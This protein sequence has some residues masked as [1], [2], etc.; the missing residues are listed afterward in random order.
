MRRKKKID[1][2][3]AYSLRMTVTCMAPTRMQEL[4]DM[5][6]RWSQNHGISFA[7]EKCLVVAKEKI[8]LKIGQSILPQVESAKYLGIP[9]CAKGP[10]WN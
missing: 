7:P 10:M 9:F 4:L 8:Q 6:D 5:C 2:Q 1:H 3:V